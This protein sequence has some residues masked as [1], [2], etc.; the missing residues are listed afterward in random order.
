MNKDIW[1]RTSGLGMMAVAVVALTATESHAQA[2]LEATGTTFGTPTREI[3]LNVSG[4]VTYDNNVSR[5]SD[6]GVSARG[7][8][9]E[10][11]RFS[12]GIDANIVLPSGVGI[13]TLSG[14]VGYDFYA[15]NTQLDRERLD[16]LAG[17]GTKLAI[18]D[19][20]T[21]IGYARHQNDLADLS[22]VPG[23]PEA[24]TVNV[25]DNFRVGGGLSCGSASIRPTAFVE[26]RT[27][28]NSA[29]ERQV[30]D[31]DTFTYGVGLSYTS[32]TFGVLTAFASR[33]EF[34]FENR[35]AFF[36]V[37]QSFDITQY[38]V[39]L[40]R[41]LGARL[42][43]HGQL[44]YVNVDAGGAAGDRFDGLNWDISATLRVGERAQLTMTTARQIDASSAF[45]VRS[46]ELTL[47]SASLAYAVSPLVRATITASRRERDFDI[48]PLL[49]PIVLLSN[50]RLT[51]VGARVSYAMGRRVTFSLS[52]NYQERAADNAI[53]DYDAFR[54]VFGVSFRL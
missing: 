40:D 8:E 45:N 50:D 16:V 25:Q 42:Q 20:A 17:F 24:S 11:F 1:S 14:R 41:R 32:P 49:A 28:D 5:T 38:G 10:D 9:K 18:C 19:V 3:E 31:V 34:D 21:Q 48:D 30:S 2:Q 29:T 44:S 36:G 47:Y 13:L 23:D 33:S 26:Y 51:E 35:G 43:V 39:R 7:I 27:S 53:Y 12:P 52:G 6:A 4:E 54:A 37:L 22:I 46:G 15:R